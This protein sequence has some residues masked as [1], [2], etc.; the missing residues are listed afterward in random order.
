MELYCVHGTGLEEQ[1]SNGLLLVPAMVTGGLFLMQAVQIDAS[2]WKVQVPKM[3][4]QSGYGTTTAT[5]PWHGR[6]PASE[7][8]ITK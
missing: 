2:I 5:M 6:L 1:P 4:P 8:G 3:V 7:M